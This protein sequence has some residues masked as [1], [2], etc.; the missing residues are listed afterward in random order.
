M[1]M[2]SR[3]VSSKDLIVLH[4]WVAKLRGTSGN[5]APPYTLYGVM[6]SQLPV[7]MGE[8]DNRGLMK[9]TER[10]VA[11]P[12][13]YYD[14]RS[15]ELYWNTRSFSVFNIDNYCLLMSRQQDSTGTS[16][17][18]AANPKADSIGQTGN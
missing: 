11:V 4:P 17:A 6:L 1:T 15:Q 9:E 16:S 10:Q 5:D 18:P 8:T 7:T 2:L 12:A 14:D 3:Q 13:T